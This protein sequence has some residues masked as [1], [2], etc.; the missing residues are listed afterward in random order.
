MKYAVA[1][2]SFLENDLKIE[3]VEAGNWSEA[4][5]KHSLFMDCGKPGDVS[6]LGNDKSIAK[7]EAIEA[8]IIFDVIEIAGI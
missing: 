7:D 8:D 2:V 4:L 5:S 1:A 6:W 3:I